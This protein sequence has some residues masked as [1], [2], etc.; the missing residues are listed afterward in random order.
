MDINETVLVGRL[1]CNPE[2]RQPEQSGVEIAK[3]AVATNYRYTKDGQKA[4]QVT[5]VPCKL[6]GVAA[7]WATEHKKGE[8]IAVSGRLVGESWEKNGQKQWRLILHVERVQ[9][10]RRASEP[11]GGVPVPVTA[12]EDQPPF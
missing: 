12:A 10:F 4:E 1:A 2:C 6:F 9:F 7:D 8:P 5:Y 11:N 3:F